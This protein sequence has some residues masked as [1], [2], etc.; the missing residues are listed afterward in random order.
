MKKFSDFIVEKRYIIFSVMIA[1]CIFC[2]FL[3]TRINVNYDMTKYLPKDSSMKQGTDIMEEEFGNTDS[4]ALRL[5]FNNLSEDE[6]PEIYEYL[7]S[8]PNVDSVS[9]TPNSEDYNKDSYTLYEI[10]IPYDNYSEESS[11]L[12]NTVND[13]FENYEIYTSGTVST[14]NTPDLPLWI[15]LLAIAILTAILFAMSNSWFEPILFLGTIVV[16]IIINMGTNA[17]FPSISDSS[18]SMAAILQIVL[19]M[20]YSIILLNR[21]NQ[22]KKKS[23]D[24]KTA[25]KSAIVNVFTSVTASSVT[26]IVGLLALIFMSFTLGADLGITLAKSVAISLGC[27]FTVMPTL[28][29]LSDKILNK[30]KKKALHIPMGGYAKVLSKGRFAYLIAFVFIFI[31]AFVIRGNTKIVY[32]LE[33]NNKVDQVFSESTSLVV[34]YEKSDSEN[35]LKLSKQLEEDDKVTSVITYANTLG[36]FYTSDELVNVM[37]SEEFSSDKSPTINADLIKLVYYDYFKGNEKNTIPINATFTFIKNMMNDE[38]DSS[39]FSNTS[40]GDSINPEE[41]SSQL[42]MMIRLTDTNIVNAPMSSSELAQVLNMDSQTIAQFMALSNSQSMSLK[43]FTNFLVNNVL[44]NAQYSSVID[45]DTQSNIKMMQ[46]IVSM[47]GAELNEDEFAQFTSSLQ[48]PMSPDDISLIYL[49]YNALNNFDSSWTMTLPEFLNYTTDHITNDSRFANYI[50]DETRQNLNDSR[51]KLSDSA[52]QLESDSYGRIIISSSYPEDSDE[53]RIFIEKVEKLCNENLSGKHYLIGSSVMSYEMSQT[54]D[55][56]MN[57]ITIITAISIFVVV[58]ISFRSLLIPIILVSI[59]QCSVYLTMSIIGYSGGSMYYIALLIV[60]SILMGATVD[61]AILYT[62]YYRENRKSLNVKDSLKESYNGA[63]HSIM[64]SSMIM[65]LVTGILGFLF[66]NP[67]I[68]QICMTIAQG[69]LCSTIL[70]IFILPG[71]LASVD[72]IIIRKK[73]NKDNSISNEK[74][75]SSN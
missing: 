24:N 60:Q 47:A 22:E 26:T 44:T 18:F 50:D 38:S 49:Y 33:Q 25:M 17:F 41:L 43:D 14:A 59:V 7:K 52:S 46:K 13:H 5:M 37:T 66:S 39:M 51:D 56:E 55:N 74:E 21:Y 28:V 1:F 8:L 9:W 40:S 62:S 42:D 54:F 73:K 35:T 4:S 20:D 16:A 19:S 53:T 10:N 68:G 65:I 29:L 64:T 58:A 2:G 23:S 61:Y 57:K 67:S 63:L 31:M 3:M 12:F 71:I 30:T 32:A 27:I 34:L 48:F 36:G 70:I 72:R 75:S 45:A 69:A 6:K 15:L 11:E